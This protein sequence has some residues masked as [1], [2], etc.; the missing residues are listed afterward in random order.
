LERLLLCL[1]VITVNPALVTSG[2][3]R[4]DGCI[5]RGDPTKLLTG[6]DILLLLI[7]CHNPGH[8]FG[9][10]MMHAQF[11]SQN[12]LKCPT[13]SF[14]LISKVLNGS[15]SI[16]TNKLLKSGYSAGVVELMGLPM[17]WSF[18]MDV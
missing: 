17:C 18:S 11:N 12:L 6:T 3:P 5:V 4:Q 1:R 13:S 14:D 16:L 7:S 8:K 10:N 9:G 2:N 15:K